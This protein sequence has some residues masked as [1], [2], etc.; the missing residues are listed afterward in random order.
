LCTDGSEA[1]LA[2]LAAGLELLG[3]DRDLVL[4]TV[5]EPEDP[6][7][8]TGA[9]FQG[10]VMTAEEFQ[11]LQMSRH[12][13][14]RSHLD[15]TAEQLGIANPQFEVLEGGVAHTICDRARELAAAA[16]VMGTRGR[17]GLKR[18][19]LGSVSDHVIR[20][21]PCPVVVFDAPTDDS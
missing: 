18:A 6:T 19:V 8:V 15:A 21:A 3:S 12:A 11:E 17:R 7:L 16:I 4:V 9:G 10:G 20:N 14:A 13:A 5:V 1:A 2:A